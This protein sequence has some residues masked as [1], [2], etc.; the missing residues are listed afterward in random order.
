MGVASPGPTRGSIIRRR[1]GGD[2]RWRGRKASCGI[3][4]RFLPSPRRRAE[5]ASRR[6]SLATALR[7]NLKRAVASRGIFFECW[8]PVLGGPECVRARVVLNSSS[9]LCLQIS[10]TDRTHAWGSGECAR[11]GQ[12]Q[13][14]TPNGERQATSTAIDPST[15]F[16]SA[17]YC[18][19]LRVGALEFR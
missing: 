8:A 12:Q 10:T 6:H 11:V 4:T 15:L 1:F 19:V 9:V 14:H 2:R 17:G 7:R 13:Q 5:R 18:R 16:Y 3:A